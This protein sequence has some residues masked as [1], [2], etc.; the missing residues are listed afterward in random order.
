MV[1]HNTSAEPGE[2]KENLD[3][4]EV[5]EEGKKKSEGDEKFIAG[6]FKS[7]EELQEHLKA[8]EQE[9]QRFKEETESK[10]NQETLNDL[11]G[12]REEEPAPA[13]KPQRKKGE[14]EKDIKDRLGDKYEEEDLSDLSD[15][16]DERI[17]A[18]V[19]P[20]KKE[21]QSSQD[22]AD[23]EEIMKFPNY[24]KYVKATKHRLKNHPNLGLLDCFK[25]VYDFN[26][27]SNQEAGTGKRKPSDPN[28]PSVEN[29]E[30]E[31]ARKEQEKQNAQ[32]ETVQSAPSQD[33]A[34]TEETEKLYDALNMPMPGKAKK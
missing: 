12:V 13:K 7:E 22:V 34:T 25:M 24:D 16:I 14:T 2:G 9:N 3:D 30:A 29:E 4:L 6:R 11:L 21:V 26:E 17:N 1:D 27:L 5:V 32:V 23:A 33:M 31:A 19:S 15:Y 18:H 10:K 8:I 28:G 20:I